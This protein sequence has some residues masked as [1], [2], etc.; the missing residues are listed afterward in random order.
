MEL[1]YTTPKPL[2]EV[3]GKPLIRWSTSGI[4]GVENVKYIFLVLA[5]HIRDFG[6]DE[7]LKALYGDCTIV[8]VPGVTE[9]AACTVLLAKPVLNLEEEMMIVN[10]DDLFSVD[11]S[12]AKRQAPPDTKGLIFYFA[13]R[14]ERYSYVATDEAGRAL[15]VAEKEVISDK[16]TAGCY[17]FA[18]ARYF[19]QAAEE[20]IQRNLRVKNEFYVSPVFNVL[21]DHGVTIHT[22]PCD[23]QFSLGTPEELAAF[24]TLFA[25]EPVPSAVGVPVQ[26]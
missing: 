14:H 26:G 16:A 2:I 12:E 4:R 5:E 3:M 18:Q 1:G 23:F 6:I 22:F 10:C 11:V 21:I 25:P 24:A 20:M 9:G 7:Q 13:S 15:K 17:Y 19:T 8:P